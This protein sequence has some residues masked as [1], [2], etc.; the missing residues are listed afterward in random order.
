MMERLDWN[1]CRVV[2]LDFSVP[3]LPL[4]LYVA[5]YPRFRVLFFFFSFSPRLS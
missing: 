5:L 1:L 4:G 3:T 2:I